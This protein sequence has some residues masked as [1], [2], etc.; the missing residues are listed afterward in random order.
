MKKLCMATVLSTG[1][2][3]M[4]CSSSLGEQF[5]ELEKPSEGKAMVYFYRPSKF[6]GGGVNYNVQDGDKFVTEMRN[7]GYYP[8]LTETGEKKFWAKTEATDEVLITL[9]KNKTYFVKGSIGWGAFVG[10]PKLSLVSKS[11][12]LPEL[13]ECQLILNDEE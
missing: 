5:T 1:L 6:L 2:L 10:H 3:L 7:G 9:E 12:A 13:K 4:G 8:Y 11:I